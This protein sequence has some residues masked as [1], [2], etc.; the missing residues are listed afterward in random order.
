MPRVKRAMISRNRKKKLF[1]RAKGFR[2]ARKNV[3][4]VAHEAVM[5]A[6][7]YAYRDRRAKKR[8]FRRLWIT[9]INTAARN[10]GMSYSKLINGLKKANIDINRKMLADLAVNDPKTFENIVNTAKNA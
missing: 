7:N 1:K 5:K 8:D 9:R 2:M 6:L 4:K 3:L 10:S